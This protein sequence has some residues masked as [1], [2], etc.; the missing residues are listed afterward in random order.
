MRIILVLVASLL[1]ATNRVFANEKINLDDPKVR[2]KILKEAVPTESLKERGPDG[3]KLV[4]QPGEQTPYT[5]WTKTIYPNGQVC[6][7][8]LFKD[9]KLEG[10]ATEWNKEGKVQLTE[11]CTTTITLTH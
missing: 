2:E 1:V 9:G 3:E 7:L 6:M 8:G 4:Y 11:N 10:L 5:G